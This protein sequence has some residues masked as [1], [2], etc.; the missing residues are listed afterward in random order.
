MISLCSTA[1]NEEAARK[2]VEQVLRKI[3]SPVFVINKLA[4]KMPEADKVFDA[5]RAE[6]AS[7]KDLVVGADKSDEDSKEIS[8]VALRQSEQRTVLLNAA[9][10]SLNRAR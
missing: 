8:A 10:A 5:N 9:C 1:T 7:L 4:T 3:K 2:D 6:V